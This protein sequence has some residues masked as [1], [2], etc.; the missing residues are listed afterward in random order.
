MP[1]VSRNIVAGAECDRSW[2]EW[3]QSPTSH[4]PLSAGDEE[5]GTLRARQDLV[6]LCDR[7][8]RSQ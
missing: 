4:S 3:T 6:Q 5:P 8:L 2:A 1:G 7:K